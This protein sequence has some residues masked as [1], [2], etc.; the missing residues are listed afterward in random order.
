MQLKNPIEKFTIFTMIGAVNRYRADVETFAVQVKD[1]DARESLKEIVGDLES[2]A[3]ELAIALK[4]L[5]I[6]EID[7]RIANRTL[8]DANKSEE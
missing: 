4:S 3:D 5:D 2:L 7:Y 6:L 1:E 8:N